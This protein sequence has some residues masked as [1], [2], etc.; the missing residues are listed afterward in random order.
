MKSN[1][2]QLQFKRLPRH[3]RKHYTQYMVLKH[4]S[5]KGLHHSGMCLHNYLWKYKHKWCTKLPVYVT[6][7]MHIYFKHL[8]LFFLI[9]LQCP[10]C[11]WNAFWLYT[12]KGEGESCLEVTTGLL[13]RAKGRSQLRKWCSVLEV[14]EARAPFLDEAEVKDNS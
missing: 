10:W 2:F 6:S 9:L 7:N 5:I 14:C 12:H 4:S 11:Y 8:F 1:Y 13:R 3:N